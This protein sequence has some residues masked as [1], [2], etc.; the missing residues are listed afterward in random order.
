M[1]FRKTSIPSQ[2]VILRVETG[3][4]LL[5]TLL[6]FVRRQEVCFAVIVSAIGSATSYR[7]RVV[8]SS[9]IPPTEAFPS[10]NR[11]VDVSHVQGYILEGRVH[12]HITF[13]DR[14]VSFGGH[15]EKGVNVLTVALL[16][17]LVLPDNLEIGNWDRLDQGS[18]PKEGLP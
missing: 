9:D 8:T 15:L 10:G 12:A 18:E 7:Y 3:G 16:T 5:E 4:D 6:E 17:L 2:A 11:A 13:S 1:Q 14:Q